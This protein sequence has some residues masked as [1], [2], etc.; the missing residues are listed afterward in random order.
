MKLF[1]TWSLSQ[2]CHPRVGRAHWLNSSFSSR[3]LAA[4][5]LI[6]P[7]YVVLLVISHK[8]GELVPLQKTLSL[9]CTCHRAGKPGGTGLHLTIISRSIKWHEEAVTPLVIT[10][11]RGGGGWR[12]E[13]AEKINMEEKVY[14]GNILLV[15]LLF[16]Q[17]L[18]LSLS[19][20]FSKG[21][22]SVMLPR[23]YKDARRGRY[24][25]KIASA[26]NFQNPTFRFHEYLHPSRRSGFCLI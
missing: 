17:L 7:A 18:Q 9:S 16:F 25:R 12:W 21:G 22:Y 15:H 6:K 5:S 24:A 26:V 10:E 23:A 14:T 13:R 20:V 3:R 19:V 8:P 1:R 11:Q 4:L 2:P